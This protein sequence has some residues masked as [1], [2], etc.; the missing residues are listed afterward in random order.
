MKGCC[1]QDVWGPEFSLSG[2]R[3]QIGIQITQLITD[4][5]LLWNL[6]RA[7]FCFMHC[8]VEYVFNYSK[9]NTHFMTLVCLS[10]FSLYWRISEGKVDVKKRCRT[11]VIGHC[12]RGF[13]FIFMNV[14][15][16]EWGE[17]YGHCMPLLISLKSENQWFSCRFSVWIISCLVKNWRG[18]DVIIIRT[19]FPYLILGKKAG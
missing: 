12:I 7:F 16:C 10:S 15:S 13:F 9:E 19:R 18:R 17:N 6:K 1:C 8:W 3:L 2:S 11:P 14:N 5:S 4:H